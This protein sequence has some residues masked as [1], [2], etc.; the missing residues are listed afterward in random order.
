MLQLKAAAQM[1]KACCDSTMILFLTI[2]H[3]LSPESWSQAGEA[4][5]IPR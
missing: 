5:V 4:F 1:E 3:Q 2:E